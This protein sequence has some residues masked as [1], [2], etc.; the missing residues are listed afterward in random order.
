MTGRRALGARNGSSRAHT[1]PADGRSARY[2]AWVLLPVL[3]APLAHAPV[4]RWD[5]LP[6]LRRPISRRLF[7]QNKTWRGALVMTV[8]TVAASVA[9][10]RLP[11]YRARLPPDVDYADATLVGGLLGISVWAGELPNSLLK[12]RVGIPPGAITLL[13]PVPCAARS[14]WRSD[15]G[16]LT[17]RSETSDALA[18]TRGRLGRADA[19]GATR[20]QARIRAA[21]RGECRLATARPRSNEGSRRRRLSTRPPSATSSDTGALWSP[22]TAVSPPPAFAERHDRETAEADQWTQVQRTFRAA[23]YVAAGHL[24]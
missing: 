24:T 17:A 12:R 2:A 14:P 9:L 3:G 13:V 23:G 10:R 18:K 5:L 19:S 11:A 7:G 20:P 15:S 22:T 1:D 4:L 8:S 21:M 16:P 6:G